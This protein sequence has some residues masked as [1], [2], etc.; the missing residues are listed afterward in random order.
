VTTTSANPAPSH[1]AGHPAG[2][3][4]RT[5]DGL[6]D[7]YRP[8]S[9]RVGGMLCSRLGRHAHRPAIG[10]RA[11]VP[12]GVATTRWHPVL[13]MHAPTLVQ[14]AGVAIALMAAGALVVADR[15]SHSLRR[16]GRSPG[17]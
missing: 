15:P 6:T 17:S 4:A 9:G 14:T 8:A 3:T 13:A 2:G 16:R 1:G 5:V 12:L 10:T 7:I 11:A